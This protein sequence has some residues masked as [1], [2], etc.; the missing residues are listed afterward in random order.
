[1]LACFNTFINLNGSVAD[2]HRLR[3]VGDDEMKDREHVDERVDWEHR[4]E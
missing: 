2:W 4:T 3:G 1:M